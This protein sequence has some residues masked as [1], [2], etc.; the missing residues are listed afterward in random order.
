LE[1]ANPGDVV[2]CLGAGTITNWAAEL[3]HQLANITGE[4]ILP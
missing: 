3:P 2:M 4:E 1:H